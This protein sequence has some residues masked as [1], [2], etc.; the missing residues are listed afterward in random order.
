MTVEPV[1]GTRTD[2]KTRLSP[3]AT[4]VFDCDGVVLDSNRVKTEA[5]RT[6]ARPYGEAA[7]D[8]LVAHHVAHGGVSRYAKFDH[9]LQAI[10]PGQTGPDREALLAAYAGAVAEGL[11]ACAIAPGLAALRA[12][13]PGQCWMIV[14]GGDQAE[15]RALFAE[16]DLAEMFDGGIYGSPD[17]KDTILA[18]EQASG[19]LSAPAVFLGDSTYDHRAAAAAGLDFIFISGW[20]EVADW[21][22]FVNQNDLTAVADLAALAG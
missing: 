2:G 22:T 3:Y 14:S 9:F 1:S 7:A 5:F 19:T 12:A 17:T 13:H 4:V 21:Q 16:R 6:A 11:R 18:R 10:V 8:A 15:L 20:S